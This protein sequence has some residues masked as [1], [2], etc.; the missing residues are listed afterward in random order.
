M[1]IEAIARIGGKEGIKFY[2]KES[3][4]KYILL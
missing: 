2:F 3:L 1:A 4:E